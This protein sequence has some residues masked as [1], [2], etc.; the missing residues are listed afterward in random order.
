MRFLITG[1]AGFIGSNFVEY[2]LEHYPTS[3]IVVLD[4]LSIGGRLENL[5]DFKDKIK[6]VKGD[7]CNKK[8]VETSIKGCDIVVNFAAETHV[9]RSIVDA[10]PF[11]E[12]NI[13]GTLVLLDASRKHD[14]KKFVQ[15]STDEVY[16]QI[17]K[18]SFKETDI[19]NPRNPY[20]ATKAGAELLCKSYYVTH[21]LPVVITRSSNN[22]GPK[23]YPEKLIPRFIVNALHDKQLPVYGSGKQIRD[24]LYVKDNCS[25]IDFVSKNGKL[26][27]VYNIGG[28]NEKINLEIAKTIL[29]TMHKPES[30]IKFVEDRPGH[31]FRYSLNCE[32]I[33][34]LGWKPKYQFEDAFKETVNWY[35]NNEW[36]WKPLLKDV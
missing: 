33:A 30:L 1:A 14:V 26:G 36:W 27:E 9:D 25:G 11:I 10:A 3:E 22:F 12:S 23:Q 29:K 35:L 8:D 28:G 17:L 15:I 2:I 34:K 20:S 24:W 16:G 6:F 32:K 4:K 21:S 18:G 5:R 19:L 31:D 13:T 7:I